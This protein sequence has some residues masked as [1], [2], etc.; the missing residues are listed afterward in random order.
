MASVKESARV[1]AK[2]IQSRLTDELKDP[3]FA[4]VCGSGLGGLADSLQ[5]PKVSIPYGDIPGFAKTTAT[6]HAGI[7]VCGKLG[8]HTVLCMVGR[9]HFYEGHAIQTTTF[10][11]RVFAALNIGTLITTNAAGGL[12]PNYSVGDIMVLED[13]INFLGL[14]GNNP[15]QGPND[16]ELGP[17]FTALS[18]AYDFDLRRRIFDLSANLTNRTVQ[19]G[20]Y[21][22]VSGPT[23]ESRAE[24]RMLLAV[25]ADAVGMSTVPEV[26]VARHANMKVLAMSLIT[27]VA[28]TERVSAKNTKAYDMSEGKANHQ[29][30]LEV[31]RQAALDLQRLVTDLVTGL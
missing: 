26:L 1:A 13:H 30:V 29:E 7:L 5:E 28:V 24:C 11:I 18:D 15:L 9:M 12:N 31:G 25:G 14:T 8:S 3:E 20:V 2:Y 10:P 17:R 27:N 16:E 23:Y 4:I 6:G 21:A 19:E 22:F